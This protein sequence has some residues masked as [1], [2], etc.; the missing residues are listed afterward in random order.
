[1][2]AGTKENSVV[3]SVTA[4]AAVAAVLFLAAPVYAAAPGGSGETP[5]ITSLL[6]PTVNFFLYATV[7]CYGY[8]RLAAPALKQR[9]IEVKQQ[10]ER[11]RQELAEARQTHELLVAQREN[12]EAEKAKVVQDL[13]REGAQ[14]AQQVLQKAKND[15][16]YRSR[17]VER[18][19][20]GEL[21]RVETQLRASAVR[22]AAEKARQSLQAG[23]DPQR[24]QG[25]RRKAIAQ[26][27]S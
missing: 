18:R 12:I 27:R 23:L 21:I 14:L 22:A 26:F 5:S 16:Q 3:N 4:V 15:A 17:D 1:M 11:G 13:E 25:L 6:W 9:R 7:I 10:Y 8:K 24:D 19:I 2:G 20:A